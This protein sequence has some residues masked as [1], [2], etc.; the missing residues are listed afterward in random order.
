MILQASTVT[1][2]YKIP[3]LE[4]ASNNLNLLRVFIRLANDTKAI[5]N[6]KYTRLQANIDEIGRMLGGWIKSSKE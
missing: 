2:E 1:K 5:N 3:I 6:K 4:S